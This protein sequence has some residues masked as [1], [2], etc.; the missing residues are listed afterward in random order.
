[1]R[2]FRPEHCNSNMVTPL[3]SSDTGLSVW[4]GSPARQDYTAY[5]AALQ[6]GQGG[7]RC[8]R[9]RLQRPTSQPASHADGDHVGDRSRHQ[10]RHSV[11][12]ADHQAGKRASSN[13]PDHRRFPAS[14]D[15]E[16][17]RPA[18]RKN[19][20]IRHG[21]FYSAS[22]DQAVLVAAVW[23]NTAGLGVGRHSSVAGE[24]L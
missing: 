16:C 23:V 13:R 5:I 22:T 1:M 9:R 21:L 15:D 17:A 4:T 8:H 10:R 18:R 3:A 12:P 20:R 7:Q 14:T 6:A 24:R 19:G 11:T 2:P